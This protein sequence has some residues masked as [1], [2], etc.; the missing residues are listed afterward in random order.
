MHIKLNSMKKFLGVISLLMLST[1]VTLEAVENPFKVINWNVLY[2]FNHNN[3]ITE[4]V[5]WINGQTPDVVALQELNDIG[6]GGLSG[7]ANQWG[8]AHSAMHSESG[9]SIGLTS[10]AMIEVLERNTGTPNKTHGFLHCRTHGIHFFVVHFRPDASEGLVEASSVSEKAATLKNSGEKV[11]ILGDFNSHSDVDQAYLEAAGKDVTPIYTEVEKFE[12]E[13]FVDLGYKHEP[14]N[15]YTCPSP[16]IIPTWAANMD[17]VEARRQRIDFVFADSELAK[18]SEALTTIQTVEVEQVSDHYPL[19]AEFDYLAPVDPDLFFE[20]FESVDISGGGVV[21]DRASGVAINNLTYKAYE[22]TGNSH[23]NLADFTGEINKTNGYTSKSFETEVT[24]NYQNSGGTALVTWN[25]VTNLPEVDIAY[26]ELEFPTTEDISSLSYQLDQT[27]TS[28]YWTRALCL[29]DGSTNWTNYHAPTSEIQSSGP[30]TQGNESTLKNVKKIRI[31]VWANGDS[32]PGIVSIDNIIIRKWILKSTHHWTFDGDLTD[33]VG[34]ITTTHDNSAANFATGVDGSTQ[35]LALSGNANDCLTTE[36]I[37]LGTENADV[38]FTGWFYLDPKDPDT[39]EDSVLTG[40]VALFSQRC[41]TDFSEYVKLMVDADLG[42]RAYVDSRATKGSYGNV[43]S[44]ANTVELRKWHYFALVKA[45]SDWKIYIDGASVASKSVISNWTR[46]APFNIGSNDTNG[47]LFPGKIDELKIYE[48]RALIATEI[49]DE[50]QLTAPASY[51]WT[52]N[53]TLE[54][55]SGKADFTAS[56]GTASYVDGPITGY[57]A[58]NLDNTTYLTATGVDVGPIGT[59][60]SVSCWFKL[61]TLPTDV[62]RLFHWGGKIDTIIE[63]EGTIEAAPDNANGISEFI[64]RSYV[65]ETADRNS[66]AYAELSA[67]TWYQL[68]FVRDGATVQFYLNGQPLAMH[69][70]SAYSKS[71][72]NEVFDLDLG[73]SNGGNQLDCSVSD[74][75]IYQFALPAARI[76]NEY[77]DNSLT[78]AIGLEVVQTGTEL[79]WTAEDEVGV[80]EYRVVD[81]AT[82]EILEVVVAGN[83]SYSVTLPEGI[84]AKLVVVDNSGY[85][86]TFVPA[87]GNIVKVVYDLKEGWN[88]IALPGDNA[89]ITAL[90]DVTVGDFWTWNS[91]AYEKAVAPATCQ[92]IWVYAPKVVQTIVT[93]EKSDAE[94]ILQSGWNLVGPKENI[95]VPKAA[96]TVY[97]WNE[98]YQNIATEDG[99]LLQGVGYW[100]FSL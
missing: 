65:R 74:F 78:P 62:A 69:G 8:H 16:I 4:G 28:W 51:T 6:S 99:V 90:K 68:A 32:N 25:S 60:Y 55:K 26:L 41:G 73:A 79:S 38:S 5:N 86:Q 67:D 17:E 66:Y 71:F 59:E 98:T 82:G 94:I 85:T 23:T 56:A 13:G 45:G 1:S 29:V 43:D 97:S 44:G 33:S 87:D 34:G 24:N 47:Q 75:N 46:S 19:I 39:S 42:V 91:T 2:G 35:A 83:G 80:K 100:I 10:T 93:A 14:T 57:Q 77:D 7:L 11:V 84:E 18:S 48:N 36:P 20:D 89:D 52:F 64:L 63:P 95:S 22:G 12:T 49:V 30:V 31:Y 92:G 81:A 40:P 76:A 37:S 54:E 88:L 9:F 58:V 50:Y 96:Y 27:G 70:Y 72:A 61:N 15:K 3:S 53:E 21:I